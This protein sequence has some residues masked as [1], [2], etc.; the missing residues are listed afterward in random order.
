M[1]TTFITLSFMAFSALAFGSSRPYSN[2]SK[3]NLKDPM[4]STFSEL[5]TILKG[6]AN[7]SIGDRI[8]QGYK[9]EKV[10]DV[11]SGKDIFVLIKS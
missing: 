10:L 3:I 11:S 1:K 6:A 8:K 2:H 9:V 7:K 5:R 4:A